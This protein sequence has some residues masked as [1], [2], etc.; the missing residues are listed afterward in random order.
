MHPSSCTRLA[1]VVLRTQMTVVLVVHSWSPSPVAFQ[2]R[3][4]VRSQRTSFDS[5]TFRSFG[6]Q[7]SLQG[8]S[9]DPGSLLDTYVSQSSYTI[10]KA[11]VQT[12]I[13]ARMIGQ[14]LLIMTITKVSLGGAIPMQDAIRREDVVCPDKSI[15]VDNTL[16]NA[17]SLLNVQ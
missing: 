4:W 1:I 9:T 11:T 7:V 3:P 15:M 16:L 5:Y 12:Q 13:Q 10:H 14:L 8:S 2:S 6:G 17:F